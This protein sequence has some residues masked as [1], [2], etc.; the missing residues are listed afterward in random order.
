VAVQSSRSARSRALV[1]T[2]A[3]SHRP[4]GTKFTFSAVAPH[5]RPAVRPQDARA[6]IGDGD[7][8]IPVVGGRAKLRPEA[9]DGRAERAGLPAARV[10][11]SLASSA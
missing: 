6:G 2:L 5:D 1:P 10:S 3:S 4:P 8:E 7:D 11:P 9:P